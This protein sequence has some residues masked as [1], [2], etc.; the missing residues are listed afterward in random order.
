MRVIALVIV[1]AILALGMGGLVYYNDKNCCGQTLPLG[2]ST[3][4]VSPCFGLCVVAVPVNT[5]PVLVSFFGW[6]L[7]IPLI[8][9]LPLRVD[10][11]V[12]PPA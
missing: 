2:A 5:A 6:F 12:K 9:A 11:I 7:F 1:V 10:P 8:Y 4:G 3:N